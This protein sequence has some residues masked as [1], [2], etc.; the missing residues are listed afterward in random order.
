[1]TN[2]TF[3]KNIMLSIGLEDAKA[4]DDYLTKHPYIT[5]AKYAKYT[6]LEDIKRKTAN[7]DS[8]SIASFDQHFT[9]FDYSKEVY[10]KGKKKYIKPDIKTFKLKEYGKSEE[11]KSS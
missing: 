5:L 11:I 1:M 4:I 7:S 8:N 9:F 3:K 2:K 6:I 10:M